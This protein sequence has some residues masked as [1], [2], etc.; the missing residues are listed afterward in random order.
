MGEFLDIKRAVR[1]ILNTHTNCPVVIT[2]GN[3][4]PKLL[5]KSYYYTTKTGKR[6]Y[7]PNAYRA[8][9]GKPVYHKSTVRIEVGKEWKPLET[10]SLK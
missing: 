1:S 7:H 3:N 4:A 9:W 10:K 5:G 6:V 2:D 8:A